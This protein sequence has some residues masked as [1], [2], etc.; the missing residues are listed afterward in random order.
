MRKVILF[1]MM[2]LDGFFEGPNHDIN[3]HN[4]DEEFNQFAIEQLNTADGLIFG[5]TTYEMMASYWPTSDAIEDDPVVA[6]WMN[7]LPKFV[8]FRTLLKADWQ[9]TTLIKGDAVQELTRLKQL[10]GKD[11]F[12]FGSADL[13]QTFFQ[14]GL[15]DEIRV[16]INPLL[17]GSG[18][19]QFKQSRHPTPLKLVNTR[20]FTNGNVLLFYQVVQGTN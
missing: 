4:V 2:T 6:G 18:T 11:L 7:K 8:F 13:A 12:I 10:P 17:L 20:T 19:P 14:N 3:W 9:N 5:R 15:I 16:M 1:N